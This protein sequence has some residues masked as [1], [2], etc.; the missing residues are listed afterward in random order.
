MI[1]DTSTDA[2]TQ[3]PDSSATGIVAASAPSLDGALT[4]NQHN[5]LNLI[6]GIGNTVDNVINRLHPTVNVRTDVA[7][8]LATIPMW[9]PIIGLVFLLIM[10]F[11]NSG[12]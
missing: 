9:L 7:G 3:T 1:V 12:R 11:K 6:S 4:D 2:A 5:L 10:S 8:S